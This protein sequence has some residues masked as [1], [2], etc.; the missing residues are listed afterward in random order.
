MQEHAGEPLSQQTT[1]GIRPETPPNLYLKQIFAGRS[2]RLTLGEIGERVL[3]QSGRECRIEGES[4]IPEKGPFIIAANHYVRVN[5]REQMTGPQKMNDLLASMGAISRL[6][7]QINP[8]ITVVWTPSE[9]PRPE[10]LPPQSKNPREILKWFAEGAKFIPVN[11]F[12]RSYKRS[13]NLRPPCYLTASP[14]CRCS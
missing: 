6:I 13:T 12:R 11:L 14:E 9:V 2:Q 7:R 1:I 10:A 8:D 4:N 5:D 3:M